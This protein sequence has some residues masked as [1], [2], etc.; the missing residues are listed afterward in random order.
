[1][2]K[3]GDIIH[4]KNS[5]KFTWSAC[6]ICGK[7]RWVQLIRNKLMSIKCRSCAKVRERHPNW[8]GGKY[9]NF[10]GYVLLKIESTNPFFKMVN[11]RGYIKEHRLVMAQYLDR[12]L[13]LWEIPH[14]ING[15]K[16]D[17]RIENLELMTDSEHNRRT[18]IEE[19]KKS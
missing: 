15:V 19:N 4:G 2:P 5:N 1:M 13:E 11:S 8:K 14:H 12:C 7:E 3:V 9:K 10:Y 18:R 16:N 17:N 6:S